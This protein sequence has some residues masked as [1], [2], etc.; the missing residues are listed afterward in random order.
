MHLNHTLF[1]F[2]LVCILDF[3]ADVD[4]FAWQRA[5]FSVDLPAV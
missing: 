2:A 3:V 5:V 1:A 4:G